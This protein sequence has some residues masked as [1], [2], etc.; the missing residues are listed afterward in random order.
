[1]EDAEFSS[2]LAA[3]FLD[4]DGNDDDLTAHPGAPGAQ[5]AML[6]QLQA[7]DVALAASTTTAAPVRLVQGQVPT[8]QQ[9]QQHL[10]HNLAH[11]NHAN[12]YE[13]HYL[14]GTATLPQQQVLMAGTARDAA[15]LSQIQPDS[16]APAPA[17]TYAT[18]PGPVPTQ[19]HVHEAAPATM[20]QQPNANANASSA[21]TAGA[22]AMAA[23]GTIN[24]ANNNNSNATASATNNST[25]GAAPAS[26][27]ATSQQ[28]Q[29]QQQQQQ[30]PSTTQQAQHSTAPTA[31]A[32]GT[33]APSAT[34]MKLHPLGIQSFANCPPHVAGTLPMV[35][36]QTPT[37][38]MPLLYNPLL[39]T[40]TVP[41]Q[42]MLGLPT[43]GNT[44][45]PAPAP[46]DIKA[47][48]VPAPN[49]AIATAP[50][51]TAPL[52][53]PNH[54]AVAAPTPVT[55]P[56]PPAPTKATTKR[57]TRGQSKKRRGKTANQKQQQQPQEPQQPPPFYLFDAPIE[58]RTNFLQSQQV[59]SLQDSNALHYGMA[60]NGF[61]PQV[62]AQVNPVLP[63]PSAAPSSGS[64]PPLMDARGK[65]P[66]K[67][68]KE[69]NEREQKRAQKI[70]E[71]IEKLRVSMEDGGWKVEVKSKYH[72]LST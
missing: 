60:V 1:M 65:K 16:T 23:A 42:H 13:H 20:S 71:L 11:F 68:G 19:Q 43:T 70:T 29:Q 44:H 36:L 45:P 31:A 32:T 8:E 49:A 25:T 34:T 53:H 33:A 30:H 6:P 10:S 50:T 24:Q 72:T 4:W 52:V 55:T 66:K 40:T 17:A 51:T 54:N 48:L 46:T 39:G 7:L 63:V 15:V 35:S 37:T 27:H 59:H 12:P 3:S 67:T 41:P 9:Q 58:L 14:Q 2:E 28:Q 64:F 61:H 69:R 18:A 57:A 56:P 62:N 38:Y 21:Q 5:V 26:A 47:P 22:A